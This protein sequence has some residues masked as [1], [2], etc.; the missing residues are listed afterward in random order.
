MPLEDAAKIA[1]AA[2]REIMT[3]FLET[4][5]SPDGNV[6]VFIKYLD[7]ILAAEHTEVDDISELDDLR[8][9]NWA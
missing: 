4:A 1:T 8:L 6:G 9:R 7:A 5:V 3:R 2:T